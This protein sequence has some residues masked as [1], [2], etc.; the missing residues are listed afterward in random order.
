MNDII[1]YLIGF[2][3]LIILSLGISIAMILYLIKELK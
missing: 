2:S 1:L 3:P